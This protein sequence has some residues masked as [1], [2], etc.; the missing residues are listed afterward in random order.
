M[1]VQGNMG[2]FAPVTIK[3]RGQ[4]NAV[5]VFIDKL[6]VTLGGI[7]GAGAYFGR[8][9]SRQGDSHQF[10]QGIPTGASVAGI[11]IY[12]PTIAY[13]SP[14]KSTMYFE[15]QPATVVTYG[16][17]ELSSYDTSMQGPT[18]GSKII[19]NNTD[20][21][22]AFIGASATVPTGWTQLN[23]V[24]Y[25]T[26]EP[27]GVKIWINMPIV[28]PNFV[29]L[30][31]AATPVA[32]PAA[33]AVATGTVVKITSATPS[34]VVRYTLDGTQPTFQSPI[35][36]IEGLPINNAVTITAVALLQGMSPSAVLTA[37]Y[38]IA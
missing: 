23:A 36:P 28:T 16:M 8:V 20:G 10:L 30:P 17:I 34:A 35:F 2:P 7:A 11:L 3:G 22:I 19:A 5:P 21:R 12:D 24:V 18:F 33:G 1:A 37:A 9:V 38:T 26:M 32:S 13:T 6:P 14:A 27:N 15:G 25:D 4:A 29:A 31:Q